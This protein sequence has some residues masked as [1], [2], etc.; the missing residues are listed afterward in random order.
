M[1]CHLRHAMT[2]DVTPR[3]PRGFANERHNILLTGFVSSIQDVSEASLWADGAL[4]SRIVYG[5]ASGR[6]V[7][8]S[9]DA[10]NRA[11]Y[12]FA[13]N[14]IRE[15]NK[16][17]S[18]IAVSLIA[19]TDDGDKKQADLTICVD[20]DQPDSPSS[21]PLSRAGAN[22]RGPRCCSMSSKRSP[23]AAHR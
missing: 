16:V 3:V 17:E 15:S 11:C 7:S 10:A 9:G 13:F 4:C 5:R 20:P 1:W 2:I 22:S 12:E 6:R 23:M 18:R 19:R 14:L 8:E 21:R